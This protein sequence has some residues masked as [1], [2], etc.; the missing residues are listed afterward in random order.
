MGVCSTLREE[1][2]PTVNVNTVHSASRVAGFIV[3]LSGVMFP[4][5]GRHLRD[6][7]SQ[8]RVADRISTSV[9]S[10]AIGDNIVECVWVHAKS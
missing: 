4:S 10:Q 5:G 2:I 6:S 3:Y 1:T 7:N 8:F 9:Y